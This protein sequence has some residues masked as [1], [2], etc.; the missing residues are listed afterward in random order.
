MPPL[1]GP[2][3]AAFQA[4]LAGPK[5]ERTQAQLLQAS[6]QVFQSVGVSAAT[7]QQ[8]AQAAGVTAGTFYNHFATKDELLAR[9]AELIGASLC[10]A[11]RDSAQGIEDGAWRMAIGQRRYVGMGVESPAWALLLIDVV[12]AAPQLGEALAQ[13]A[14]AD[15]RLG[16]RQ[17]RFRVP[18]EDAALDVITGVCLAATRRVAEG[19]APARHDVATAA[20]VLRALGM[21]PDEAAE[22][23]RRPLPPLPA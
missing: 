20:V 1:P 8:V 7:V 16:V 19:R 14:L 13:D 9:L 6:V 18:S 21:P 23:A 3:A 12:A 22:L 17:K 15:L 10:R 5:R 2:V 11:I 4:L